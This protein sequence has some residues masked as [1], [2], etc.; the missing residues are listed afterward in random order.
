LRLTSFNPAG[1]FILLFVLTTSAFGQRQ[2]GGY[3]TAERLQNVKRNAETDKS[4]QAKRDTVVKNAELWVGK[5]DEELWSMVPAQSLPRCIDVTWDYDFPQRPR[6]GCLG[7][8][9]EIYKHG[10]YPYDP[11]FEKKP[12]KLTCPNC[13]VVFPTNDFGKYYKS[14]IDEHGE[15]DPAKADKA[16]LFNTEHPDPADPLHKYGVDDGYGF[17]KKADDGTGKMV[18]RQ[19]KYI[20]Y[21]AWKYW[22][23][24]IGGVNTLSDAYIYTG[25]ARYAH[26]AA[27][28]LDRIADVYPAMDWN[29]YAKMGWYHSDGS[30]K[31]GKI[32]GRIW[33]T[34]QIQNL[35]MSYD[36]IIS[37]TVDDPKLYEF[38]AGKA[39]QYK[40]RGSKGTR[41]DLIANIDTNFLKTAAEAIMSGRISGNEGMHQN[42]M[43]CCALALNTEPATSQWID[44]IFDEKGGHLPK[45][46]IQLFDRDGMADEAAPGYCYLWPSK[47]VG[48]MEL[49]E[50]YAAYTRH[51]ITRDFPYFV[52][53]L[54]SPW[55]VEI[56]NTFTP[57]IGDSGMT[58]AVHSYVRPEL[59]AAG[60]RFF[61]DVESARYAWEANGGKADGLLLDPG[62]TTP[63]TLTRALDA[64]AKAYSVGPRLGENMAGYGL[65]S[66][67]FGGGAP[68]TRRAD[69]K[70]LWLYYGR[71]MHHGH[72]DR[73]NYGLYAFGT[74]L[75][76]DLGYPEMMNPT[77][78]LTVAWNNNSISH[79]TV[80][81]NQKPQKE[82]WTGYPAFYTVQPGFGA[83]EVDSPNVY[84]TCS[85]YKR[86][87][88]F[89]QAPGTDDAYAVDVF[90]VA[91]GKDHLLSV[92][93]PPGAVTAPQLN[94]EAQTT[95]T[96]AG[97]DVAFAD[98]SKKY[99]YGYSYLKNVER[100]SQ[101]PENF[102]LDW[103]A[104]TGYRGVTEKDDLHLRIHVAGGSR[105][106]D[107]ALADGVAPQNKEGNPEKIR[108]ALLHRKAEAT[109]HGKGALATQFVSV[110]EPWK[111]RPFIRQ[112]SRFAMGDASTSDVV[113]LKVDFANGAT[114]YII[115]N[116]ARRNVTSVAGPSTDGA[117][118]WVRVEN[119]KVTSASL[120][121]GTSLKFGEFAMSGPGEIAG[122]LV[123]F[124]K[125]PRKPAVAQVKLIE[126][127]ASGIVGSQIIFANDKN[128]NAC[129]DIE[130]AEKEINTPETW[131]I[132]CGPGSF[133]RGF[134]DADDYDKGYVYNV[135][136][137][138]MFYVPLTT[139]YSAE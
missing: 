67:E 34:Q 84:K 109:G 64:A 37:G 136:E 116:P 2:Y 114:D 21:Y 110:M 82:N 80:L 19:Y 47:I 125:N 135:A 3:Y 78:K 96:Y 53:S 62:S 27:I 43:A 15:F 130:R 92:H 74:N 126:G 65:A 7:C 28:L 1:I 46:L 9:D 131:N 128:R 56:L 137:G 44:W 112:V 25:D 124:E 121:R 81:V 40:L 83:V 11:D 32:E 24:I 119:G 117:Y 79:N 88:A 120:T 77:W 6:L 94:L 60:F 29:P 73:L 75:M 36:K 39:K 71:N 13:G 133:A 103:K 45:M 85:E 91:G 89:I 107:I 14:G 113:G 123:S 98:P 50:P 76:P 139:I 52:N 122:K 132:T 8:G 101:P 38:L 93:G 51:K 17:V 134:V 70:A 18:D 35:A 118:A 63:D 102:V 72:L 87:L 22:R 23:Y 12:W 41:A 90:R 69:G 5:S 48:I 54:R 100:Q 108:Y 16:L 104:E 57:N 31:N 20:A 42:S 58:G 4:V 86:T 106:T 138:Q 105:L 97:K 129:Y 33:E 68:G 10:G 115:S 59:M 30:S 61:D 26:K 55:R 99:P 127:D 111:A 49:L 66:F 95:G